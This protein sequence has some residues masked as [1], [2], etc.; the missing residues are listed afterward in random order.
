MCFAVKLW[1]FNANVLQYKNKM[2]FDVNRSNMVVRIEG[3]GCLVTEEILVYETQ[4]RLKP[5]GYYSMVAAKT[6]SA[7][8]AVLMDECFGGDTELNTLL[9]KS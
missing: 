5:N 4:T 1:P 9:Y 6:S 3:R 7:W 8:L 2:N